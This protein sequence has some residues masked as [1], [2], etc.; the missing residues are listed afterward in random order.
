M[1]RKGWLLFTAMSVV[2]SIPYLFI[3]LAVRELDP[4]VVVF[5]RVGT[6]AAVLLPVA[7]NR[8]V[9]RQPRRR[10]KVSRSTRLSSWGS[11]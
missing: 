9:L 8:K 3:K 5:A 2:W 6:A 10:W 7:A 1:T 4:T 11:C